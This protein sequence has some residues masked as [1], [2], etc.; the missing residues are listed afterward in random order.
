MCG[1]SHLKLAQRVVFCR[2][3]LAHSRDIRWSSTKPINRNTSVPCEVVGAVTGV[4]QKK[5]GYRGMHAT[6]WKQ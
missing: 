5:N 2:L 4:C 1:T 6:E 3:A